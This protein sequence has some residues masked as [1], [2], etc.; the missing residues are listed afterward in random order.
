MIDSDNL[1][2]VHVVDYLMP[3]LG[4]QEFLLPKWNQRHG[5]EVHIITADRYKP[6]AN[7]EATWGKLLGPRLLSAGVSMVEGVHVHRLPVAFELRLRPWLSGLEA[8]ISQIG[9]DVLFV[10]GTGSLVAFHVARI[11]RR[12]KL[13]MLMDNHMVFSSRNRR[14]SGAAYYRLLRSLSSRVLGRATY[15]FL[16]VADECCEFL[17]KEQGIDPHAI[18]CLPLAVDTDLFQPDGE[19]RG[20]V[21]RRFGLPETATVILQTGKLAPRKG[22]HLLA[23][24]VAPLLKSDPQLHLAFVG[25][26]DEEYLAHVRAPVESLGVSAQLHFIPLVPVTELAAVYSMADVVAYPGGT[27]LSCLEASACELPV[28]M[29][30]LPASRWRAEHGV[31]VCFKDGDAEDLRRT[32]ERLVQDTSLRREIGRRSR[33]AVL[34]HFSYDAVARR[35][36]ELMR[37]AVASRPSAFRSRR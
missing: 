3:Q 29:T 15:K 30:D 22:P 7:Y 16:G 19:T 25:G 12:L 23:E 14:L 2:I 9:P 32:I 31:G 24:A 18:E 36:E 1:R 37:E 21:R 4:Y 10:H 8:A 28:V 17:A 26:G 34:E 33:A 6:V 20:T 5:H 13:P 35:S 11:A 27:S